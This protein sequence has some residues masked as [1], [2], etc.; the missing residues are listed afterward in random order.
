MRAHLLKVDELR[1][2]ASR[3]NFCVKALAARVGLNVRTLE[4]RFRDQFQM[5]PKAWIICERMRS[6]P[7]LLAVG[8]SNKE[9]AALLSYTCDSNFCRDFKRH[10]GHSPQEF[11][12]MHPSKKSDVAF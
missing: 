7:G 8:R 4:R 2:V 11:E 5:T 3:Q 12:R 1:I 6:A 9:V 10:Y